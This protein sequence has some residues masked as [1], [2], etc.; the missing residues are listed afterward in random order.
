MSTVERVRIRPDYRNNGMFQFVTGYTGGGAVA[1]A[2]LS[3]DQIV[4]RL[5]IKHG[6]GEL[7]D[8][9]TDL[10]WMQ[11]G[12]IATPALAAESLECSEL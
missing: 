3:R 6:P 10:I 2:H 12:E 1:C 4:G 8:D 7:V 5:T 11:A 9:G